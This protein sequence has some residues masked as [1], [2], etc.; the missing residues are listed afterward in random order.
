[1]LTGM[2]DSMIPNSGPW[3]LLGQP[4]SYII[5]LTPI[6][7]WAL[8]SGLAF[9]LLKIGIHQQIQQKVWGD[10]GTHSLY[11]FECE[12]LE[13]IDQLIWLLSILSSMSACNINCTSL[14]QVYQDLMAGM[15]PENHKAFMCISRSSQ[16][17]SLNLLLPANSC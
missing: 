13:D 5:K 15:T 2:V 17:R 11:A 1:M 4:L 9:L 3:S 16:V 8:P 10:R 7:W 12:D 6:L 14:Q